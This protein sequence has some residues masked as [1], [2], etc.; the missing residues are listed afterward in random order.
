MKR[1]AK[2]LTTK[3]VAGEENLFTNNNLRFTPRRLLRLTKTPYPSMSYSTTPCKS[4]HHDSLTDKRKTN[5]PTAARL[6]ALS[7]LPYYASTFLPAFPK[8]ARSQNYHAFPHVKCFP[9]HTRSRNIFPNP[10]RISEVKQV[11][12]RRLS[13]QRRRYRE[14]MAS[15]IISNTASDFDFLRR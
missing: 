1:N 2:Q 11:R 7:C 9:Q 10:Q 5:S 4:P 13:K 8:A 14:S 3:T 6:P 12:P 15:S